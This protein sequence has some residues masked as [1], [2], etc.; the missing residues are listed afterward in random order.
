[1]SIESENKCRTCNHA[2][3]VHDH[4]GRKRC[5]EFMDRD[6]D[7]PVGECFCKTGWIP[8]DNLEFLEWEYGRK[9]L[10]IKSSNK[11]H[12]DMPTK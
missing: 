10:A 5:Y 4:H 9:K 1:M 2:W 3:E 8:S 12:E 6:F 11:G 7:F